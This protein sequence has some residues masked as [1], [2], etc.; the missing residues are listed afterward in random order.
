MEA[1]LCFYLGSAQCKKN[2][3]GPTK[4]V[5]SK[6]MKLDATPNLFLFFGK[7]PFWL[8]HHKLFFKHWAFPIEAQRHFPLPLAHH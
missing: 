7:G 3:Y 5:A 4:A 2:V 1:P 6:K 8:A